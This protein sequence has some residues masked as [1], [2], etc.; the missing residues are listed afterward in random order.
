MGWSDWAPVAQD[1]AVTVPGGRYAQWKA[2]LRAGG[3]VDSVGLNY[4]EKNLAPVVDEVVVQ[5]DARVAA[6]A[7]S[8]RT[9]RCR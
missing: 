6:N 2:V 8:R 7:L 4:L 5:P 3:S 9:Q 1:G